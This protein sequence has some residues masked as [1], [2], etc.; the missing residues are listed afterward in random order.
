MNIIIRSQYSLFFI[1]PI[2][3]QGYLSVILRQC[4][5]FGWVAPKRDIKKIDVDWSFTIQSFRRVLRHNRGIMV[6][7]NV[8]R[9]LYDVKSIP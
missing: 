7:T 2:E 9:A 4:K 8:P 5:I 1:L 6:I 3:Y